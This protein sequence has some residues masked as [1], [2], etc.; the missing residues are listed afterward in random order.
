GPGTVTFANTSSASTTASFSEAGTYVLRLTANDTEFTVSDETTIT[1]H[2][3][4]QP[5]VVS[6]GPDLVVYL[7]ATAALSGT[8]TDDGL[9]PGASLTLQWSTVSGPGTVTFA[10]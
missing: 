9:P 10:N 3:A 7:P 6:A 1:V 8:V 4:N 5:P 2:P